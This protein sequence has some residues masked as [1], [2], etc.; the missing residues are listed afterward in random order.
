MSRMVNETMEEETFVYDSDE[1]SDVDASDF[2]ESPIELEK[3]YLGVVICDGIP[4]VGKEKLDKLTA[5]LKKLFSQ[6]G[7]T[8]QIF[9]PLNPTTQKTHGFAFVEY[10]NP[11]HSQAAVKKMN[12]FKLD[13]LHTF[14]CF[15]FEDFH[16]FDQMNSEYVPPARQSLL[17]EENL[18]EWLQDEKCR[19]QFV[20]RYQDETQVAWHDAK[21]RQPE[22]S[23]KSNNWTDS[24]VSWSPLG[25]YLA[26]FHFQG[27]ALWGGS[28]SWQ[29][30]MRMSH[31]NVQ[32]VDFSP[33]ERYMVTWSP[34]PT[35]T[36]N[37]SKDTKGHESIIIWNVKTGKK[38]RSFHDIPHPLPSWPYFKWSHDGTYFSRLS[39]DLLSVYE[40]SNHENSYLIVMANTCPLKFLLLKDLNGIPCHPLSHIGNLSMR[41]NLRE[42][43]H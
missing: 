13:K 28:K 30:F 23:Q 33:C 4:I 9:M 20:I 1:V 17:H 42:L 11:T 24:F 36:S 25:S 10:V 32:L 2:P 8:K 35:T 41:I 3:D 34:P 37:S 16:Y 15:V 26:T 6:V 39:Q 40:S 38:C 19:D 12:H 29:K 21:Q 43:S 31:E 14:Q 22:I 7:K 18:R 27:I 5:V